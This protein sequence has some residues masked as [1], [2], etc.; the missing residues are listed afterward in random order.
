MRHAYATWLMGHIEE[1][2]IGLG[3]GEMCEVDEAEFRIYGTARISRS[4]VPTVRSD[5]EVQ[6]VAPWEREILTSV[7]AEL[8]GTLAKRRE[9][10]AHGE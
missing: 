9:G 10:D 2:G 3:D 4:D 5:A 8:V 6:S 7:A 1:H